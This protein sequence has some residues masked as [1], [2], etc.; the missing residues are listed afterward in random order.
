MKTYFEPTG[1]L[2]MS[3]GKDLIKDLP[4]A[5]VELVKNAY[6]ADAS[7][8]KITYRKNADSLEIIVMDDGHG[9]S[10]DTVTGTW[11]VPSTDYKLRKKTSPKGRV[12]QGKKGIG[13]Y[14]VSLL[15]NKLQLSTVHDGFRTT[16]AFNWNDFNTNKKLSEIPVYIETEQTSEPSGTTLYIINE[17]G[18]DSSENI[19]EKDAE[20]I[21]TELSRL[22]YDKTDFCIEVCYEN[23]FKESSR[24]KCYL[25]KPVEFYDTC[26]YRLFGVVDEK[27]SYDLKYFN[28]YLNEEKSIK[29]QINKFS[30]EN[31]KECG[32]VMID[33]RVYDKDP[34]GIEI[35]TNFINKSQDARYSKTDIRK[36][37]KE[38]SG[39]SIY[40]NGFRIRP[41]GDQG[42]DWLNLDAQR[43][44]NPSLC[45]GSEQINGRISI[46]DEETSGLKEKSARDGLYENNSYSTL[47]SIANYTLSILEQE[48]FKY[49]QK[50]KPIKKVD[51]VEKLFDFS[52]IKSNVEKSIEK[53]RKKLEK[54]PE[55]QDEY[56][57]L[58][59]KEVGQEILN[60][61]KEKEKDFLEV[62]ETIAIYQ[63]HTTLGNVISVVL[64]EGRKP[65]SWYTHK[66]PT[67]EEYLKNSY[68][69]D[70][71]GKDSY[72]KLSEDMSKL[73]AEA[74]RL[75]SFF[76]RLDPLASNKRGR[77]KKTNVNNQVQNVLEFFQEVAQEQGVKIEI[78]SSEDY[79]ANI[80]QED[81]YMALTNI[82]ENALFWVQH[83]D[84]STKTIEVSIVGNDEKIFI[85]ISDNGPGVS[86]D[87]L[88]DDI[89]FAPGYS[90]K[91]RVI[92][93]NGTGL[94]LAIAGEA[95]QRNEGKLEVID[96]SKGACFRITLNRS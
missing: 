37:L 85:E 10:K 82:I 4:A 75:S 38:Q 65:L 63:K 50:N 53:T 6:D 96:A 18:N 19:S 72:E 68:D 45:I 49:R 62:K 14:A 28:Y 31:L 22:L 81:L 3:I 61:E 84:E 87:D 9:M 88:L 58:L 8:V 69:S 40:R 67:I 16:A 57:N 51:P 30:K 59:N 33:Y 39:I 5:M 7:Y 74:K 95:I 93:D 35:I 64:H 73:S 55:K 15:G 54:T 66:I 80:I 52:D 42:Y 20:K 17:T 76:K 29:G 27:F 48:R 60:L 70:E 32:K 78:S 2:I 94:G 21:E 83:S 77:R 89:L 24:N 90:A 56:F 44:Q 46:E 26:H 47:Q 13:R 91:K 41:Y 25:I 23:F 43:V 79:F 71:L 92:E 86:S 36:I 34:E 12:Y 11:M 1:R